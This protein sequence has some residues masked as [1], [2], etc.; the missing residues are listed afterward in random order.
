MLVLFE[1]LCGLKSVTKVSL[2]WYFF[3]GI[4]HPPSVA[5]TSLTSPWRE[6]TVLHRFS[7]SLCVGV[8]CR[9]GVTGSPHLTL[10][11]NA[12]CF[13]PFFG[14]GFAVCWSD[15]CHCPISRNKGTC[16]RNT[17]VLNVVPRWEGFLN[18]DSPFTPVVPNLGTRDL[19]RERAGGGGMGCLEAEPQ[20]PFRVSLSGLC[21][22]F[23][24]RFRGVCTPEVFWK[25]WEIFRGGS[26]EGKGWGVE[27]KPSAAGREAE[28][29]RRGGWPEGSRSGAQQ[30]T[31]WSP[32]ASEEWG[33][34]RP[35]T[36]QKNQNLTLCCSCVSSGWI[37]KPTRVGD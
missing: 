25:G 15:E 35:S 21:L 37:G 23:F 29:G 31:V 18:F 11:P 14:G 22:S 19:H 1:H 27:T 26:G 33:A 10:L 17:K 30:F 5:L 6:W 8:T 28:P 7:V 4:W 24:L 36:G 12:E 20:V 13:K 16:D 3:E 2:Q 32:E 9:L 34:C